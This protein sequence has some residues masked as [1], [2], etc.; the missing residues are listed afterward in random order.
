MRNLVRAGTA[1]A[2]GALVVISVCGAGSPRQIPKQSAPSGHPAAP[3][4]GSIQVDSDTVPYAAHR[5]YGKKYFY[6]WTFVTHKLHR[7]AKINLNGTIT[8]VNKDTPCPHGYACAVFKWN[9]IMLRHPTMSVTVLHQHAHKPICGGRADLQKV[10]MY[11][12]W[13]GY[14]CSFNPSLGFA[15]PWSVSIS[16]WPSCGNRNQVGYTTKPT[17]QLSVYHQYN[18]GSPASFGNWSTD[19]SLPPKHGPC[20]GGFPS[21]VLY[22]PGESDSYGAG[23]IKHSLQICLPWH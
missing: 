14:A 18:S 3:A 21:V 13:T 16:G 6:T 17:G 9:D 19:G 23:N 8:W 2:A 20:Y 1:L 10:T 11:Q 15:I 12:G 5:T 22:L 7:C 4:V